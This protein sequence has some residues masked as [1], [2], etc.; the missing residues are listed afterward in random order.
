[1]G[2][3]PQIA[4][5]KQAL[6]G[7]PRIGHIPAWVAR[8]YWASLWSRQSMDTCPV[9]GHP[10]AFLD[11]NEVPPLQMGTGIERPSCRISRAR[12]VREKIGEFHSRLLREP[13]K[14]RRAG[15]VRHEE[16][17][18]PDSVA[19]PRRPDVPTG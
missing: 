7:N 4:D 5:R 17:L 18:A 8:G 2:L 6:A 11:G 1:M 16:P 12:A 9:T 15:V 13:C 14:D 19:R 10:P 3:D